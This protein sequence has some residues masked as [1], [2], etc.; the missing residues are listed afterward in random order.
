ME[1]PNNLPTNGQARLKAR[2]TC[3]CVTICASPSLLTAGGPQN[4]GP[5]GKGD[6]TAL[7]MGVSLNGGTPKT[8]QNDH[9]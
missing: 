3:H 9:F 4:D 2:I 6:E 7:N 5:E 1:E 8:P